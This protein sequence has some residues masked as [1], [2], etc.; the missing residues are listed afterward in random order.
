MLRR[1]IGPF[2][3]LVRFGVGRLFR[4][5]R[6]V[7]GVLLVGLGDCVFLCGGYGEWILFRAIINTVW[8]IQAGRLKDGC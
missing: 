6:D 3:L 1:I 5:W 2:G 4:L 8:R 7:V